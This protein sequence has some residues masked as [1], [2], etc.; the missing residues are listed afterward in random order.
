MQINQIESPPQ[1]TLTQS[2][3]LSTHEPT[4]YAYKQATDFSQTRSSNLLMI[5]PDEPLH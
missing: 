4:L 5:S 1:A 2:Y 3:K